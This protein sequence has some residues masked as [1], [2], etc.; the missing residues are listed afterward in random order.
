MEDLE[1]W[2]MKITPNPTTFM[3]GLF[4]ICTLFSILHSL[5]L[6]FYKQE[7]VASAAYFKMGMFLKRLG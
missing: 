5:T 1:K 2:R 7:V 3:Q 4:S 6:H